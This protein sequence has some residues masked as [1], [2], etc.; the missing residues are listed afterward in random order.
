MFVFQVQ[1]QQQQGAEAFS[2]IL[3]GE[4]AQDFLKNQFLP[5][6]SKVKEKFPV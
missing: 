2:F 6:Y 4:Q 5:V 3:K 1:K